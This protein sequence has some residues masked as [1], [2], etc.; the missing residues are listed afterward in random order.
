[1]VFGLVDR[2]LPDPLPGPG[3]VCCSGGLAAGGVVHVVLSPLHNASCT[4][5]A[6]PGLEPSCFPGIGQRAWLADIGNVQLLGRLLGLGLAQL[7]VVVE[8]GRRLDHWLDRQL[9]LGLVQQS[10]LI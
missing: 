3:D 2:C 1:M 10:G 6:G 8:T 4:S 7:L 5:L 9:V